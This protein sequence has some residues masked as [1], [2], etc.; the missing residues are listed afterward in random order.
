MVSH[1]ESDGLASEE[2][3]RRALRAVAS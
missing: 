2:V 3:I 1:V